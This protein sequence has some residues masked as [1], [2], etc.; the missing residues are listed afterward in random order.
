VQ[1]SWLEFEDQQGN[2]TNSNQLGFYLA[3]FY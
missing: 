2:K 3:R 1:A